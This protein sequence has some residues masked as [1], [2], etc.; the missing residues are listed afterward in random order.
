MKLKQTG[1]GVSWSHGYME[2][3]QDVLTVVEVRCFNL[4]QMRRMGYNELE[5]V[6]LGLELSSMELEFN[7]K[8]KA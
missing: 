2:Q 6:D 5:L 3:Q 7:T 8:K 1:D 4:E